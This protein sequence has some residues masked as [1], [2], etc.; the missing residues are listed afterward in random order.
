MAVIDNTA[1]VATKNDLIVSLVQRE[2]ISKA[3]VMSHIR[4]A[5]MFA[6]KG[7]KSIEVPR[8]DS[9]V[10]ENRASGVQ[11]SQVSVTYA[12]DPILL[13]QRSNITWIIDPDDALESPV[14]VEADVAKRA[15]KAHAKNFD[16][17]VIAGIETDSTVTT[18]AGPITKDVFLEMRRALLEAEADM[19]QLTFLF[20]PET[21]ETLLGI[22]EF[23]EA[24]IYGS[25]VIPSGVLRRV[26]GVNLVMS[27][28]ITGETYY[29]FDKDGYGFAFQRGLQIG[30]R[31]A[32]ENGSTAMLRAMDAKWGHAQLQDGDLLVK[33][34][35][36]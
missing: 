4:D 31:K 32:P 16:T 33:D 2:L 23:T 9:F 7:S 3:V 24:Q 28:Q 29:M 10:V 30:E 20:G 5:S 13:D 17:L 6:T 14:A 35:N 34:N 25:P 22:Q 19:D 1:L 15:A 36:A 8:A 21:E 11:G 18:T 12:T 27:T 26:Y